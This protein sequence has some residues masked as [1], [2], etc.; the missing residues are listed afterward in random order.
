VKKIKKIINFKTTF[1][2]QN[3]PK[4]SKEIIEHD[5]M[6]PTPL[7]MF[8]ERPQ[9]F[10]SPKR[11]LFTITGKYLKTN[12][13]N[14]VKK[15]RIFKTLDNFDIDNFSIS[16]WKMQNPQYNLL[17]KANLSKTKVLGFMSTMY[18]IVQS[19]THN[20]NLILI[21]FDIIIKTSEEFNKIIN[22]FSNRKIKH[23]FE[24]KVDFKIDLPP[25]DIISYSSTILD[26]KLCRI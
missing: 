21:N 8:Y 26:F 22:Q 19:K 1:S 24:F 18:P 3:F 9:L 5:D 20:D 10:P 6:Y 7:H 13:D 12:H 2:G 17:K 15:N 4:T 11:E 14:F 23:N 25:D 16:I